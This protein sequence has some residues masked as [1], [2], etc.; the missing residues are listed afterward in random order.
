MFKFSKILMILNNKLMRKLSQICTK[1]PRY[2]TGLETKLYKST[3]D[4]QD[5]LRNKSQ[6][7][8]LT[9]QEYLVFIDLLIKFKI[10]R[11]FK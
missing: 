6:K 3:Q 2:L 8:L 1:D 9:L 10:L 11:V 7:M 5:S 4:R